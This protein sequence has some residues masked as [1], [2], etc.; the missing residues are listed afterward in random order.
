MVI[1]S[2]P[3]VNQLQSSKFAYPKVGESI[4][5]AE[6]IDQFQRLSL[7]PTGF[8]TIYTTTAVGTG[9][10]AISAA[11]RLTLT[12]G[13]VIGDDVDLRHD[14]SLNRITNWNGLDSKGI[15]E[16]DIVFS[17]PATVTSYEC[18]LG[19]LAVGTATL[20]ALP[21]TAAHLGLYIDASV[22]TNWILTSSNGT[23]QVT[24]DTGVAIAASTSYR[25]NILWNGTDSA[26]VTLYTGTVPNINTLLGTHTVTALITTVF[27]A[28][29]F[30]Q[31]E[32]VAARVIDISEWKYKAS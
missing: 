15:I 14:L 26:V 17:T 1:V 5:G 3:I 21:T 25:L 11:N 10:A 9:T 22:S 19:I 6:F 27:Y 23:T 24:T 18:F 32:A 31:T 8:P 28:H 7:T 4:A 29:F 16:I 13:A 2:V 20:A 30:M 12:T